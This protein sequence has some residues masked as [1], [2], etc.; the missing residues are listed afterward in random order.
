MIL[1][2]PSGPSVSTRICNH[3]VIPVRGDRRI[4]ERCKDGSRGQ[5]G[6]MLRCWL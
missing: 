1:D 5:R 2:Y 4:R 6:E 3:N